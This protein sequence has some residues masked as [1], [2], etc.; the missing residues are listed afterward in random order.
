MRP[1]A[2]LLAQADQADA[3]VRVVLGL[4]EEVAGHE[5]RVGRVVGDDQDL[6]R[7]GQQVDAAAAE[8]LP[9]GLGHV[10]VA[11]AA[12]D[13]DRLH[14]AHAE[15]HQRERRHAA[16]DEDAVGAGL[17]HRVDGGRVV[18]LALDRRRAGDDR[19]HTRHLGGDDAHLR[20]AEHRVAP[21]GDVAADA[22]ATGMC[23]WPSTTPGRISTSQRLEHRQLRLGEARTLS[24]QKSVSAT[25]CRSQRRDRLARSALALSSK[26]WRV[27]VVE[28]AADSGARRPCRSSPGRSSISDTISAVSGSCSNSRCPPSLM[29]F[30]CLPPG[31]RLR[32]S[33]H[34]EPALSV[35]AGGRGE[36]RARAGWGR[37]RP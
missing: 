6:G 10:L 8:Q 22:S 2:E 15:G 17:V 24:W 29:T 21:A 34:T 27:P 14:H 37:P 33:G 32:R 4:A 13:V 12:E 26:L 19:L 3:A 36:H 5:G 7:P 28:L 23:L 18:A 11:R 25:T 9:L 30:M 20:R 31:P 1:A 16:E 35:S